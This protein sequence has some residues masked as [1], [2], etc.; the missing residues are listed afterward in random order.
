MSHL[1]YAGKWPWR[2][3]GPTT[4]EPTGTMFLIWHLT[5]QDNTKQ[6]LTKED[7]NRSAPR[8]PSL[9]PANIK[10]TAM[11]FNVQGHATDTTMHAQ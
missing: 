4:N 10:H 8:E 5:W 6:L 9:G 2:G 1:S 3:D 7:N 11:C